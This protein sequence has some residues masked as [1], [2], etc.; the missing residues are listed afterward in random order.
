MRGSVGH[1]P[2]LRGRGAAAA[3]GRSG[4]GD[5]G[6]PLPLLPPAIARV[7]KA[8]GEGVVID[9]QLG[10]LRGGERRKEAV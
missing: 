3:R 6:H 1:G 10:D 9:F 5:S 2:A 4:E 7:P 8:L